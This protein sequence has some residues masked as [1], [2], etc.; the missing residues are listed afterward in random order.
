[1][2]K[3]IMQIGNRSAVLFLTLCLALTL[4]PTTALA[5]T[6]TNIN[7]SSV[8]IKQSTNYTCTLASATMMLRRGAILDGNSNWNSITESTMRKTAWFEN[9]G[10]KNSFTYQGMQVVYATFG[11]KPTQAKKEYLISILKNHAEGIVIYDTGMPHAILLT[12]YDSGSDTFYCSDPAGNA[13]KGRIKLVNSTIP[14]TTQNAVIGT[15]D[16]FWYIK[17]KTHTSSTTSVTSTA[18]NSGSLPTISGNNTPSSLT[19]GQ[20]F[21]LTGTISSGTKLTSV[22]VGVYNTSGSMVTGKTVKPNTTSYSI[23]NIDPYVY[24]NNLSAGTYYYRVSATNSAGT[25]QLI[26]SKFTVTASYAT[27]SGNNAPSSL[28]AGQYFTLTGTISSGTKLTSVTVG[29]YNTSGS[30]VTGKTV[31]PNTTSYSISN[32]DPYVYF[33]NLSAGTYY[34]RVSATNSAGTKQLVNSKFTV[35]AAAAK[36]SGINYPTSLKAGQYFTL[37]GSIS[38]GTKLTSVTVGVYNTSGTMVTGKTVKPNTTSY[39]ITNI[40]PY[41]YF[42]KLSAGTYYYRGYATNSAG[43]TMLYNYKFTVK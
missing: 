11:S 33:N 43:T 31:K 42:N 19:V 24:F 35:T 28:T 15:I 16:G 4:L 34:Y 12:D 18:S 3:R 39:S 10:L 7:D 17:N 30:M 27:I 5:T 37:K 32:I 13:A 14:G 23:S 20:Y 1:M 6:T 21:T 36:A 41:V 8:F 29:V 9:S 38:S 2:K 22:T 40:D 25:K 26:N